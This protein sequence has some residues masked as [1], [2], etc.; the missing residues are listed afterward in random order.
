M[1]RRD[2]KWLYKDALRE[3][4]LQVMR[5]DEV[6]HTKRHHG[7]KPDNS[8]KL[9]TAEFTEGYVEMTR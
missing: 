8:E 5:S 6:T 4:R 1:K 2:E 3:E 7:R 9:E